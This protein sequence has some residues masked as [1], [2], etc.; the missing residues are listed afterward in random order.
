MA[1]VRAEGQDSR[2]TVGTL[3]LTLASAMVLTTLSALLYWRA[4]AP[5]ERLLERREQKILEVVTAEV[6]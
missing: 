5:L 4:M 3:I 6:E 1:S 2:T